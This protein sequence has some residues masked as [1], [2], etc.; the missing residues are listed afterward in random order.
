M[1][2]DPAASGASV[3]ANTGERNLMTYQ[4]FLQLRD[5]TNVFSGLMADVPDRN[6]IRP[7]RN[8]TGGGKN[9]VRHQGDVPDQKELTGV[10]GS[11]VLCPSF[12]ADGIQIET[13]ARGTHEQCSGKSDVM[14]HRERP[15]VDDILPD[16]RGR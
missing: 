5:Q 16:M 7:W 3:G 14:D 9:G 8:A 2:T 10:S 12:Y 6:I 11:M 15:L 13:P 4:E 1:L